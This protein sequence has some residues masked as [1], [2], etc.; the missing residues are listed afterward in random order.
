MKKLFKNINE[1]TKDYN[2]VKEDYTP[3]EYV[4]ESLEN[5]DVTKSDIK[6]LKIWLKK[7]DIKKTRN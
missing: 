1:I 6:L 2:L 4:Q 7:Y 3:K 5:A